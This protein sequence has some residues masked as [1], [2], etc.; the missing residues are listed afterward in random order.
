MS[1]PELSEKSTFQTAEQPSYSGAAELYVQETY[2]PRYCNDVASKIAARARGCESVLEFG[3]GIG[4]LA[5]NFSRLNGVKPDCL[6]IDPSLANVLAERGLRCITPNSLESS[7]YDAIYSS[8]VLEHIEDD[9]SALTSIRRG[10]R[11]TGSLILYLP[12]R[13]E[14][15]NDLDRMVGH[16]RRYDISDL[17]SKL[18]LSGFE[19][20][21]WQYTDSI[22]YFAWWLSRFRKVDPSS[23]LGSTAALSFYDSCIFPISLAFDRIGLRRVIGKN[24]VILAKP[25]S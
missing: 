16:Y 4:T 14:I 7:S 18:L 13:N 21:Q 15:Y 2:L 20:V 17:R 11:S 10:L 8:N 22:G 12:A 19:L 3:A 9:V 25:R 5:M 23:K 1:A 24:I 6:E